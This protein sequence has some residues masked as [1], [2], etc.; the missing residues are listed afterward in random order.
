MRKLIGNFVAVLLVGC[1]ATNNTVEVNLADSRFPVMDFGSYKI[2]MGKQFKYIGEISD[3]A[4]LN[5][6]YES[7]NPRFYINALLFIDQSDDVNNL[8]KIVMV[9]DTQL[10]HPEH[11]FR[12]E[13]DYSESKLNDT[14]RVGY[15]DLGDATVAYS[16]Q[17]IN[18][19][20]IETAMLDKILTEKGFHMNADGLNTAYIRY[21]KVIG[22]SR[23]LQVHYIEIGN[24]DVMKYYGESKSQFRFEK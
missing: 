3:E 21:G 9:I 16:V 13:I 2:K 17:S 4:V 18:E 22:S 19:Y 5:D 14:I 11:H 20:S 8:K 23:L 10:P 24:E 15:T 12:G 7:T 1:I 6:I